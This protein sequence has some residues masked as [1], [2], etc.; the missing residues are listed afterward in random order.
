MTAPTFTKPADLA[1]GAT[2]MDEK[3][4]EI[5]YEEYRRDK[6]EWEEVEPRAFQKKSRR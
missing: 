4:W 6:R 2:R 5:E 3:M 1:A